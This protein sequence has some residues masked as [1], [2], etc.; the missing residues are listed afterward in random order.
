MELPESV[1]DQVE[2]LS[3]KGNDFFDETDFSTAIAK[4]SEALA[5]LP[6]PKPDWEAYTWLSTAIGDGH[7]QLASMDA[8]RQAFFD[9]LN[10]PGGQQNPFIHYRLGQCEVHFG[11]EENGISHLLQA[12]MLDG[13]RIFSGEADGLS[14]LQQLKDRALIPE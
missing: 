4:W 8:A 14:F 11:N 3:A 12:Y 5:L 6:E 1:Y 2:K 13:E 10:G 9:A 7:Y